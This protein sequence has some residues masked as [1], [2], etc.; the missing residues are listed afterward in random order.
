MSVTSKWLLQAATKDQQSITK[1]WKP[2]QPSLIHGVTVREI[3]AV[4]TDY[5]HLNE[6]FRTE[7][8][9]KNDRVDQIFV[10]TFQ[11]GGLSAWHAHGE[12]TDRLFVVAGQMRVVLY[13]SRT[14]SPTFGKINEIKLGS[15]RPSLLVIPPKVWHGVQNYLNNPAILIN[16]VDHAYCYENP[17]HYRLASDSTTIPYSFSTNR[18]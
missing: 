4:L 18:I 11:S 6:V 3:N 17:D 12:T 7:W 10:S 15:H 14:D 9:P 5:G 8:H 2:S 16:A 1:D 13:D